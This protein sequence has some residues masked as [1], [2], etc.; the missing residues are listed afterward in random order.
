MLKQAVILFLRKLVTLWPI[1]V[2]ARPKA[3]TVFERSN[4]GI[5]GSKPVWKMDV[6][7][8]LLCVCAVLCVQV[9]T[10]RRADP[11]SKESY[12]LCKSSRYWKEAKVQPKAEQP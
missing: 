3:W 2:T 5:V 8:R 10:L 7:V 11:P 4:T 12:Q 6:C 1:T 9:A